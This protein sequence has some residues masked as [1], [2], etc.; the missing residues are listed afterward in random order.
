MTKIASKPTAQ[1]SAPVKS[2]TNTGTTKTTPK[3]DPVKSSAADTAKISKEA[4]GANA[5]SGVGG[6]ISGL[7]SWGG[8]EGADAAKGAKGEAK[9]LELDKGQTLRSGASG[10]KVTQLQE[11]LNSKGAKIDVDGKFG[12]KTMEALK[13]FQGDNELKADGIVGQNTLGKLNG[14]APDG[15]QD[16]K[17]EESKTADQP[18]GAEKTDQQ[19]LDKKTA[20]TGEAKGPNPLQ[21][22]EGELLRKGASGDKVKQLQ[23]LLNSKGAKLEVDGKFGSGTLEALKKFQGDNELKADG[24]VGSN[25]LGKLNGAEGAQKP[26]DAQG[27]DQPKPGEQAQGAGGDGR[28]GNTREALDKLPGPLQKYADVFQAAGEKYGVDPRFLA[29]ISMHE[30][31]NGTSSA[32]RNKNNAM[33]ISGKGG[34]KHISSVERSIELMAQTLAKKDGY[35]KGKNTIGAIG[36]TYAPSGAA[37]DPTGLNAYWAGGVA[38]NYKMFGGDP[39]GQ[40]VFR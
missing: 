16:Q 33:G 1:T 14:P 3:A 28:F 22:G 4:S 35:Y 17:V 15:K 39:L 24:V 18:K 31:G 30:T 37:N 25:T 19:N 32:F 6:L 11:M 38:K 27:A 40:V 10:D 36:K 34:P 12:P 8:N 7:M 20:E 5:S 29:A 13:K 21:L 2:S 23:E 9:P 26:A